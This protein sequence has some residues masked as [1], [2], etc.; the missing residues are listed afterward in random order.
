MVVVTGDGDGEGGAAV[1]VVVLSGTGVGDGA[2]VG[3][4][5]V[6]V[7]LSGTGV[8]FTVVEVVVVVDGVVVVVLLSGVGLR[9]V[10]VVVLS[11]ATVVVFLSSIT[12]GVVDV[13]SDGTAAAAWSVPHATVAIIRQDTPTTSAN[14][15]G[16]IVAFAPRSD[17][18]LLSPRPSLLFL[19]AFSSK[20]KTMMVGQS[21]EIDRSIAVVLIPPGFLLFYAVL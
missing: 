2:G 7:L 14:L 13:G 19:L 10:V 3:A 20:K 15:D 6:V 8:G 21:P 1:V 4:V 12:A 18:F 5:V 11:G 9:V 16:V 17:N